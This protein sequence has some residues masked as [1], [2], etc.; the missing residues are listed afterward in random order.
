MKII[1]T[2]ANIQELDSKFLNK[3]WSKRETKED[4]FCRIQVKFVQK[5]SQDNIRNLNPVN[6]VRRKNKRSSIYT[7]EL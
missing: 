4:K 5:K 2:H 7:V 3:P 1:K 6:T